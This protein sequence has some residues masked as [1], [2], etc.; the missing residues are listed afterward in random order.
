MVQFECHKA[1]WE[2][3]PLPLL[4]LWGNKNWLS[5]MK[6]NK[7]ENVQSETGLKGCKWSSLNAPGTETPQFH[8]IWKLQEFPFSHY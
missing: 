4:A 6:V 7:F 5:S 2:N 8:P 3:F 1:H